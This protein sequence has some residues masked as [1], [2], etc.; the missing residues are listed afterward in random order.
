MSLDQLAPAFVN[1]Q[2]ELT[3]VDKS[4]ENPF[5]HSSYAPLPE[6]METLQPLLAKHDLAVVCMPHIFYD[7]DKPHNG[8]MWYLMHSSGQY[9]SGEWVLT[10]AKRD[11]QSEGSDVTY[12]RR[13]G[14]MAITGLVA[15]EDD[16]GNAGSTPAPAKE[17]VP[18]PPPL[19]KKDKLEV[20]KDTLRAAIM[21][22]KANPEDFTWVKDETDV[23][24]ILGAAAAL[25]LGTAVKA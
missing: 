2:A 3:K 17:S 13:Y 24:R 16:D 15:D 5:F 9:L 8:L 12:K 20:A 19:R 6:V 23:D 4:A 25:N 7:G 21:K 22:A 14:I 18:K 10:P 11:P 1:F